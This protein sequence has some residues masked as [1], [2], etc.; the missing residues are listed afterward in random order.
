MHETLRF[1]HISD[2]HIGPDESFELYGQKPADR[3]RQLVR[4]INAETHFV[5]A[6]ILHTGDVTYDPDPDAMGL[7]AE[8]LAD[9]NYPVYYARG[10][11]DDPD[12]MRKY[13]SGLPP[14]TGRVNYSFAVNGLEFIVLDSFG[15]VQPQGYLETGQ[16]DWLRRQCEQSTAERLVIVLHHLPA[17]TGNAWL[18]THMLIEN[19]QAL[20]DALAPFQQ[21][22]CGGFFGHV[23]FPATVYREGLLWSSTVAA[24][25]EFSFPND[26]MANVI[27]RPGGGFS[28]VTISSDQVWVSH[29][30]LP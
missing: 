8:I 10:N 20:F 23:H 27:S 14:G 15:K 19:R 1:I 24:F 9:F 28:Q 3:L 11:H 13:L 18:D 26:S 17:Q 30:T 5:P 16:L 29:H 21:R 4:H 25:N 12:A 7:A 22:I 2:T 6:F